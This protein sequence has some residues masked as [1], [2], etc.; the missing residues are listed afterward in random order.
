[1]INWTRVFET[2]DGVGF[3]CD[4][5][6]NRLP[7]RSLRVRTGSNKRLKSEIYKLE[8]MGVQRAK[9]AARK[10]IDRHF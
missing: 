7:L 10:A 3:M 1:M 9:N 2:P 6:D 5:V 4:F 8:K